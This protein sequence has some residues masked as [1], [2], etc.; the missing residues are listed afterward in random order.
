MTPAT[1]ARKD[2]FGER[3]RRRPRVMMHVTDAGELPNGK[4]GVHF[5]C[6]HCGFDE[7][8]TE[9]AETVSAAKRGRPCP[10]CNEDRPP[11]TK[12]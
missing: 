12:E 6:G 4:R 7:G 9:L 3:P 10:N 2:L 8:W 11:Q 1:S 5:K